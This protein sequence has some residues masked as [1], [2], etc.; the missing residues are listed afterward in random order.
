MVTVLHIF[1]NR[2]KSKAT[3]KTKKKFPTAI[4][5]DSTDSVLIRIKLSLKLLIENQLYVYILFFDFY[6]TGLDSN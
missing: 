3:S 4:H 2:R 5:F 6:I 1:Q